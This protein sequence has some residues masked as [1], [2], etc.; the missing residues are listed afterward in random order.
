MRKTLTSSVRLK[1]CS[2]S[3]PPDSKAT[4][5]TSFSTFTAKYNPRSLSLS[6]SF[7]FVCFVFQISILHGYSLHC[8][9]V[10]LRPAQGT[11]SAPSRNNTKVGGNDFSKPKKNLPLTLRSIGTIGATRTTNKTLLVSL[12][13]SF[14]CVSYK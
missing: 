4:L 5:F 14:L 10:R 11:S 7:P 12:L 8:R 2:P 6:L 3:P 13:D 9:V 1:A